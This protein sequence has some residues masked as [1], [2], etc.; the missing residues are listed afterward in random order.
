MPYY[1]VNLDLNGQRCIVIGG[2]S[3]AQR[4]VETLLDFGAAVTVISDKITPGLSGL[5][6]SH[7]ITY[8]ESLFSPGM[9]EGAFLA[10]AATN[11]TE[12]NKAVYQEAKERN[13]LVNVVDVPEICT[14]FVPAVV[15]R[16]DLVISI[17]TSGKG[18]SLARRIREELESE[19]GPE[20]GELTEILYEL[21]DEVK[22]GYTGM[23]ERRKAFLRILNSDVIDLLA[24]G[25]PE[26]ARQKARQCI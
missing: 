3:V 17:S 8:N 19:Y 22:Y 15:Q 21:R 6:S 2:G 7:A 1:P 20:Y 14:F 24:Q 10:I 12:A 5:V 23:D 25:K 9:L 13:I 16:G 18:P 4:K 26:E 11:D